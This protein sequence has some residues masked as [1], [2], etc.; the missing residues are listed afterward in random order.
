MLQKMHR[1]RRASRLEGVGRA[2]DRL[3]RLPPTLVDAGLATVFIALEAA[4]LVRQRPAGG[5]AMLVAAA[6]LTL[7]LA[8]CLTVRR[9]VPVTAYVVATAALVAQAFLHVATSFS[10][11]AT[12]VGAYS[13]GLYATPARARW[14]PVL[15]TPGVIAFFAGTPGLR[16]TDPAQLGYVLL[17]WLAGWA[18]GYST[19]RRRR[20]QDQARRALQQ[21][22]IAEE[23]I[24]M[25]REL[26][27]LVGH[28]VNLLVVQAG[29]ARLTLERDPATVRELLT[30]MERTGRDTLADLDR[31][32]ATLRTEPADSGPGLSSVQGSPGLAHLPELVDP[33][34]RLGGEGPADGRLGPAAAAR[35]GPGGVPDHP[36]GPDQCTQARGT[37]RR[38]R[39]GAPRRRF[40]DH[41]GLR[42]RTR[43]SGRQQRAPW[44]ARHHRAGGDV[45][46]DGRARQPRRRRLPAPRH[47]SAAMTIRLLLADDDELLGAGL[48]LIIGTAADLQVVAQA[49]DGIEAVE[50]I[51]AHGP[52]V[53]LMDIRMPGI[54]GIE[55]TRRLIAARPDI[56]I[57]IL[58]TFPDD[59]YVSG[60]LHAGASGFLLKRAS[61]ERLLDAV[62]TVAAGEALLDPL[63]TRQLIHRYLATA[64]ATPASTTATRL[65]LDRLTDRE[66]QVLL[67]I[68]EGRSNA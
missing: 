35:L 66:R 40:G 9:R 29:A 56:K 14:G 33:V 43:S 50:Q 24:R 12:L 10:P 15:I 27:D 5:W 38:H 26:H 22:V 37:L 31:V 20:E 21:Q 19:A 58:T 42:H 45:R 39:G 4:E 32:L 49:A 7:L 67:L 52:D 62:R 6:G 23:R 60:A 3:R 55:A 48:A 1:G 18:L 54:D 41:R 13:M 16:Q 53:V 57:L 47:A 8:A 34:H 36:G 28:T 11:L 25:S 61:P 68:A 65:R 63:V 17:V 51:L 46:R 44:S 64:D 2:V 30:S 59:E